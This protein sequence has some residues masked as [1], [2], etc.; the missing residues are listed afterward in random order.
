MYNVHSLVFQQ[1]INYISKQKIELKLKSEIMI[2]PDFEK[3]ATALQN[4]YSCVDSNAGYYFSV[5]SLSTRLFLI[6][7][8]QP[9]V[10]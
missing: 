7:R 6:R 10:F 5:T 9:V 1:L 3:N 2:K 4:V 8:Q